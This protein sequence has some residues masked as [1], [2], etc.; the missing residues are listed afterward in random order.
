MFIIFINYGDF[1]TP[2]K[3]A[4]RLYIMR[5]FETRLKSTIFGIFTGYGTEEF[6]L[7]GERYNKIGEILKETY[8]REKGVIT[9]SDILD[10]VFLNKYFGI[11]IFL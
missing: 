2:N 9:T 11:P 5:H 1:V 7:A 6:D 8:K 4:A 3:N 10:R